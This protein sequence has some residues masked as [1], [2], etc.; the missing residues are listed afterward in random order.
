MFPEVHGTAKQSAFQVNN[1]HLTT[2]KPYLD[3]SEFQEGRK[4][5]KGTKKNST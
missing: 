1:P 2:Q 4:K 3:S 5:I